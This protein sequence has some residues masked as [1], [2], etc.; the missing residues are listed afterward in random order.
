MYRLHFFF[1]TF[2]GFLAFI[3][4]GQFK[5]GQERWEKA[6]ERHTAYEVNS[7]VAHGL[8]A[9]AKKLAS[10]VSFDSKLSSSRLQKS[11]NQNPFN[12][13]CRAA[14]LCYTRLGSNKAHEM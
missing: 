9:Q 4:T 5:S 14:V 8:I 7:L 13:T 1:L 11:P 10:R 2:G 12:A 6:G 3:M